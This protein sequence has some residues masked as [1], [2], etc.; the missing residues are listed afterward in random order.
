MEQEISIWIKTLT[1]DSTRYNK[2]EIPL[3]LNQQKFTKFIKCLSLNNDDRKKTK[4]FKGKEN[5]FKKNKKN[6]P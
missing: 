1:P 6:S 2:F 5:S 3:S 4:K